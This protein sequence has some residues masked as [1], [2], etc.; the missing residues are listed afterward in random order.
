M[1]LLL[2]LVPLALGQFT[3]LSKDKTFELCVRNIMRDPKTKVDYIDPILSCQSFNGTA[4][5][6]SCLCEKYNL[7]LGCYQYC[8]TDPMYS[9]NTELATN[10]CKNQVVDSIID[11]V[12]SLAPLPTSTVEKP[13]PAFVVEDRNTEIPSASILHFQTTLALSSFFLQRLLGL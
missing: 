5:Y 8:Q 10:A 3:C 1:I 13:K 12:V 2:V 4:Y 11:P 6:D 7:A 9:K